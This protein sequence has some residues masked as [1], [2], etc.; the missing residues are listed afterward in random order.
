[1]RISGRYVGIIGILVFVVLT[2]G[3]T[4]I[5]DF[6]K[7]SGSG[8]FSAYN[9]SFN[10][11]NG[12]LA[13]A[14]NQTGGKSISVSKDSSFN[15]VQFN[16]QIMNNNG[17]SEKGVINQMESSKTPGWRKIS[18]T[19]LT[20]DGKKAYKDVFIYKNGDSSQNMRF[21]Q[22]YF[23]KNG[24][25]YLILLQATDNDFDK[26]RQNFDIILNSLKVQ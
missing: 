14:D 2:S 1:M 5:N 17:L 18:N 12:W 22:I 23:V 6:V 24:K 11:P 8:N 13:F 16:L 26:E 4:S 21:E 25:T 7:S 15:G 10:Y 9:V 19:T 3:C 20:I